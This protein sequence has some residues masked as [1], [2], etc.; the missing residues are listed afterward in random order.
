MAYATGQH[1]IVPWDVYMGSMAEP[2]YFAAPGDY[3]DLYGFARAAADCLDGYEDAGVIGGP[4]RTVDYGDTPPISLRTSGKVYASLRARPQEKSAPVAIHLVDWSTRPA[5]FSVVLQPE[6]FFGDRPLRVRLLT[7]VPY[8]KALHAEAERTG[9]FSN[10]CRTTLLG[11]GKKNTF[12]KRQAGCA[13]LV[14]RRVDER[15]RGCSF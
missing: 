13:A 2:R 6:R 11:E 1:V 7:P 14:R 9:Q 8:E 12:K 3:A 4:T 15:A 10:L 5:P